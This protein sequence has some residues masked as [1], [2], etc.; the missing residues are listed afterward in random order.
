MERSKMWQYLPTDDAAIVIH[1]LTGGAWG[2]RTLAQCVDYCQNKIV[3]AWIID[4]KFVALAS[5]APHSKT[6]CWLSIWLD[7]TLRRKYGTIVYWDKLADL[8]FKQLEF[9]TVMAETRSY[10]VARL[11]RRH[12]GCIVDCVKNLYGIGEHGYLLKWERG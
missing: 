5:I 8:L 10:N 7:P 1:L 9:K 4:G 2:P 12:G 3:V 11:S 6:A